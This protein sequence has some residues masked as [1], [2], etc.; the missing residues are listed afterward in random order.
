MVSGDRVPTAIAR[1]RRRPE[2]RALSRLTRQGGNQAWIV[3]GAVRDALL[4]QAVPEID[5]AVTRDAE[6]IA[7]ELERH[8]FGTAVFVSRGRPGP[9]VF[10]VAGEHPLDIAEIEG[11]SITT[12]LARRDFTVNA[13]AVALD[14]GQIEDP[15]GGL[16][17]LA[18]RRLRCVRSG[19]R[20]MEEC[21]TRS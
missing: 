17:D 13:V 20:S 5:V 21:P 15:F 7:K 8:G 16:R 4:G 3:G 19:R 9:R 6:G 11:D 18:H 14:T 1:L 2:L 10:R 12:D